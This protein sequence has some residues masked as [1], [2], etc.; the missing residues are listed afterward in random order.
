MISRRTLLAAALVPPAPKFFFTARGNEG[1]RGA[2]S[3][4]G[5]QRVDGSDLEIIDFHEP[6]H[7]GWLPYC[8]FR[9]GR[10]SVLMSIELAPGWR[11]KTFDEYYPKSQTHLW[12]YD[13]ATGKREELATKQRLNV[14]PIVP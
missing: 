2:G 3:R 9:D 13:M 12:L 10:R 6:E 14:F 4:L 5:I 1:V 8:F 11:T 7:I